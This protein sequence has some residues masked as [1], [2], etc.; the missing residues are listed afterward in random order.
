MV[1]LDTDLITLLERANNPAATKLKD[2]VAALDFS[3]IS[4]T[5]ITYE[6]QMRGWLS[7]LA[8][9][10]TVA[11]EVDAYRRL[12]R[13]VSYYGEI[14]VLAFDENAAVV[15]QRLRSRKIRI[16]T[17][18]LRIAAIA[19]ALGATLL[20]R[21]LRDFLKVPGLDVQDWSS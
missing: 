11:D 1:I 20:S 18:D 17:M 6:E 3:E 2:R 15:F 16:G 14:R 13:H 9:A 12:S 21:N 7:Y 8:R 5:V 19:I 10:R 4:T